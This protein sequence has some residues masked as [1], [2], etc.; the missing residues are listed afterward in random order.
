MYRQAWENQNEGHGVLWPIGAEWGG[1]RVAL[2]TQRKRPSWIATQKSGL[3][4][5]EERQAIGEAKD[6][7][8]SRWT[9]ESESLW[10]Q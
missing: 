2:E 6:N 4:L 5:L 1:R 8:L 3:L 10:I 9:E 7:A